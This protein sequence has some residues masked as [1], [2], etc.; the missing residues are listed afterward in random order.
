MLKGYMVREM[1]GTSLL[2]DPVAF[3]A[4]LCGNMAGKHC[5]LGYHSKIGVKSVGP[6]EFT[7]ILYTGIRTTTAKC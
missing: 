6:R 1:L 3:L 5:R 7:C 2:E 4:E